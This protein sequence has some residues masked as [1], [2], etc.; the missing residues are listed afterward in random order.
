MKIALKQQLQL[1][2]IRKAVILPPIFT[3]KAQEQELAKLYIRVI[4]AWIKG[5]QERILPA[6]AQSLSELVRDSP[7]D[8]ENAIQVAEDG[9]VA[10]VFTFRSMIR[11]W[12][13]SLLVWHTRR[14]IGSI[15]YS[16]NI[17]LE[18]QITARDPEVNE[19]IE[20]SLARNVALVRNVSDQL[21]GRISDIVFRGLQA[22]TPVREVAKQ[23]SG[24]TGL[25]RARSLRIASDQTV[26]LSSALDRERQIQVGIV[27][28]RWKHSG[29]VHYRPHHKARNGKTFFWHSE[30][31]RTDPPGY[32]PFCGCKAQGI[33]SDGEDNLQGRRSQVAQRQDRRTSDSA[34]ALRCRA[35]D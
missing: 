29:K 17:D 2:G 14:F 35:V 4:R 5:I 27:A 24:A 22:R 32:A 15:K 28:F 16:T 19:T 1:R 3:T 11:S 31:A 6:Y 7:L 20:D 33:L 12:L 23:I 9:A 10:E 13:E 21:R 25:G 34:A 18:T 30:V 26:K 8:I